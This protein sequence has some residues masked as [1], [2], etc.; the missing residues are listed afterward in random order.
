MLVILGGSL[1][2][3]IILVSQSVLSGTAA[4]LPALLFIALPFSSNLDAT[5]HWYSLVATTAA[6]L[7]LLEGRTCM[8]LAWAGALV[9]I[10]TFFTQSMALLAVGFVFFLLWER[11]REGDTQSLLL[12]KATSLL[13]GFFGI[14]SICLAYFVWR[15]GMKQIVYYTIA[16]P[17]KYYP[18][19]WFNNWRVYLTGRPRLHSW[20]TWFDLPAFSLIHL[21]VPFVYIL[22]LVAFAARWKQESGELRNRLMLLNVA[23]LF[24]T[25]TIASAPAYNRLYAVSP[26]ALV[27]LV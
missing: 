10:A 14:L 15:V 19:D 20:P 8:R 6:L 1:V 27:I 24:L 9:G 23:G 13:V 26:P 22:C 3:L 12:K 17:V 11:G 5:H 7:I 2:W 21:I 18:S 16:F 25:L 4:Y